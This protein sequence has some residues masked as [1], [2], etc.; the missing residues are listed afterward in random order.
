[1]PT[2]AISAKYTPD[3]LAAIR[4]SGHASREAVSKK[5]IE[6]IGGTFVAMYWHSSPE[7]DQTVIAEL[8]NA[9][10]AYA[11]NSMGMASG[12]A[13]RTQTQQLRTSSEADAAIARQLTWT[14]PGQ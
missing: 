4:K 2:F 10:D 14:P 13:L 9:D 3:A 7:W 6:S 1:M 8:A 11:I 12:I 5:M